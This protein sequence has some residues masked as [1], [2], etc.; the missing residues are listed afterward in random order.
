MNNIKILLLKFT[1]ASF[2]FG[3]LSF[4]APSWPDQTDELIR[5]I[6]AKRHIPG[7]QLAI[8]KNGELIKTGNYGLSNLQDKVSV[9][10]NT[11]FPVNSM[12]KA[13]TGVA[14]IQLV[15]KG[16][17]SLDDQIGLHLPSLPDKWKSLKIKQLMAHTSGLPQILS[18]RL[19]D[20]IVL[21]DQDASWQ[22]VQSL[23]FLA[24]PNTEFSYNQTGYVAIGKII[25]QYVENGFPQ[26]MTENQFNPAGM[27][28]TGK[29]GFEYLEYV[30][31]NQARQYIHIGDNKYKNFYG[32]FPYI[33]RTAA[34]VSSTASELAGFLIALQ[35]GKL[36][37][38]LDLLWTPVT[39]NNG[40][41]SGFNSV[42]NGYAM[43]WQVID[44]PRHRA[45]SASGGNAVT[46][47]HY[48]EDQLSIVV[49]TNLLGALP[50]QFVD[51]I[52]EQYIDGFN[53]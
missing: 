4:S 13:F 8:V 51:K 15:E 39:L 35:S 41:T 2:Y 50:I 45:L 44:R 23:P 49:L 33:L 6:M 10:S 14:L 9:Q 47:I 17:L 3:M 12:T 53:L 22:K 32:E 42:E 36:I 30:V 5:Q 27:E 16:V 1:L 37:K 40:K 29:A 18:G 43:G 52:A 46:M 28:L 38:N 7:M 20:L 19:I 25:D 11:L 48:P 24:E 26:F 31:P 21:G 34:G